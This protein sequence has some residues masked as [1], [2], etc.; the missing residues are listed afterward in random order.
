ME[1]LFRFVIVPHV[2]MRRI[3]ILTCG[4]PLFRATVSLL[5]SFGILSVSDLLLKCY[6]CPEKV[7]QDNSEDYTITDYNR[8]EHRLFGDV[9]LYFTKVIFYFEN[10][11]WLAGKVKIIFDVCHITLPVV[12]D[13]DCVLYSEISWE[14]DYF[15]LRSSVSLFSPRF[16]Q[17]PFLRRNKNAVRFVR[18][19]LRLEQGLFYRNP[20]I[21]IHHVRYTNAYPDKCMAIQSD[22][23]AGA[24]RSRLPRKTECRR[25]LRLQVRM[26]YAEWQCRTR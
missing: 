15:N 3:L 9:V 17:F 21:R 13:L 22:Y 14:S 12:G 19:S 18:M 8:Y 11:A 20:D 24:H 10:A 25:R 6:Y 5:R 26:R 23:K 7:L 2:S 16:Y 1:T 4:M